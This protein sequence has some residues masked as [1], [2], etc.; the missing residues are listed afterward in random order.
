MAA[1]R[2]DTARQ[3]TLSPIVHAAAPNAPAFLLLHVQRQDGVAQNSALE[4]ALQT[5]GTRVERR[6]FPGEGLRGHME[7]NR[8]LGDPSYAPTTAVDGWLETVVSRR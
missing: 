7:I 8:R 6:E 1:F 4:A 2:S 5:A 3:R